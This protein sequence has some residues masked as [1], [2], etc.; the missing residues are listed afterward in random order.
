MRTGQVD[1]LAMGLRREESVVGRAPRTCCSVG[2]ENN[3]DGSI[4]LAIRP[5]RG[6]GVATL[7]YKAHP[8]RENMTRTTMKI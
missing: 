4:D 7:A 3:S 6:S 5:P 2:L 1:I 8:S